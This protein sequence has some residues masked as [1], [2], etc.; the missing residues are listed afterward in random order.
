MYNISESSPAYST[1]PITAAK[2]PSLAEFL[3]AEPSVI[4]SNGATHMCM[5]WQ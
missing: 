4:T 2:Y 3:S 1:F 5:T